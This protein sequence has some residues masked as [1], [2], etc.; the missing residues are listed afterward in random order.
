MERDTIK[1]VAGIVLC[2][3]QSRRMG[4]AKAL[5]PFGPETLLQ[6]VV[7]ILSS[8]VSPIVVVAA[9]GQQLPDLPREVFIARDEHEALG[10]LAGLAA[11]LQALPQSVESAFVSA[12]DVPLLNGAFVTEIIGRLKHHEIAIPREGEFYHPLSAVYRRSIEPKVRTLIAA[13]RLRPF[14]LLETCD[15]REIDVEELRSVDPTLDSLRNTNTPED[16]RAALAA[17]GY[18]EGLT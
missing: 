18:D 11:G 14:Y 8:V 3:G 6:R 1:N 2:G 12:C 10:P 4:Q 7:G 17:A 9:Q 5:L 13:D 15:V 16:Y